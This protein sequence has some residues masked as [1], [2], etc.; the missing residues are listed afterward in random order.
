MKIIFIKSKSQLSLTHI[1]FYFY[2]YFVT[3]I[4]ILKGNI[5]L[6]LSNN[7]YLMFF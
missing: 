4:F 1:I 3:W 5:K 6:K 7:E 2:L